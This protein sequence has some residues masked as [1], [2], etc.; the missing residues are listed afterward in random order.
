MDFQQ[1]QPQPEI[2]QQAQP[3]LPQE[4]YNPPQ[5]PIIDW[6]DSQDMLT[7]QLSLSCHL[8]G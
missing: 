2:Q 6:G 5:M 7:G 1:P 4:F 3:A 8:N